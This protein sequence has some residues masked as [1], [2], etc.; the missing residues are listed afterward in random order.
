[1]EDQAEPKDQEVTSLREFIAFVRRGRPDIATYIFRGQPARRKTPDG[2]EFNSFL[3]PSLYRS[4]IKR[5]GSVADLETRLM[6]DFKREAPSYLQVTP[7]TEIEWMALAQHHGLPT[8]LL[9]WTT[10]PLVALFFAIEQTASPFDAHV[11]RGKV[12]DVQIY[13]YRDR[14][15]LKED[16]D[17]FKFYMPIYVDRRLEAQ[18]SCFTLHPLIEF[19]DRDAYYRHFTEVLPREL[20]V[21]KC[22][23]PKAAFRTIKAE[24]AEIGMSYKGLFPGL[25]GISRTIRYFNSEDLVP[26]SEDWETLYRQ[27]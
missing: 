13:N 22:V 25:E 9:D 16:D 7:K 12:Y 10:N 5:G 19:Y 14:T 21:L 23:V 11:Y 1:M 15:S 24:L 6:E 27:T 26:L 17:P 18:A 3:V 2:L 4:V 20:N 8:R